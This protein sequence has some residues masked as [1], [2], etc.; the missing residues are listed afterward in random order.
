M[1]SG[2]LCKNSS[3][4]GSTDSL[5]TWPMPMRFE[6]SVESSARASLAG[7]LGST[8]KRKEGITITTTT[9]RFRSTMADWQQACCR[10]RRLRASG[11]PSKRPI[12]MAISKTRTTL[13]PHGAAVSRNTSI[14]RLSP[15]R[16]RLRSVRVQLRVSRGGVDRVHS[17][18]WDGGAKIAHRYRP[19]NVF[20]GYR[21]DQTQ[22]Q[23]CD[24]NA[25]FRRN[26][27]VSSIRVCCD[28]ASANYRACSK[29]SK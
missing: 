4:R 1:A 21:G 29:F 8:S 24:W 26:F 20:Q 3:R 11:A 10:K 22:S 6:N 12:P 28:V 9:T 2:S 17:G 27:S 23:K 13:A 25:V 19:W 16:L 14:N 7:T 5:V 15:R 18:N